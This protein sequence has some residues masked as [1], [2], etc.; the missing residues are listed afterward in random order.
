MHENVNVSFKVVPAKCLAPSLAVFSLLTP[1]L[2]YYDLEEPMERKKKKRNQVFLSSSPRPGTAKLK[3][4][5]L[6]ETNS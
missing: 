1:Y 5:Q 6:N 3:S 4:P 2:H